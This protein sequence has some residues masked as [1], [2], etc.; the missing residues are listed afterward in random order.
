MMAS[1]AE[2]NVGKLGLSTFLFW[3]VAGWLFGHVQSRQHWIDGHFP[4]HDL[5]N[6][7]NEKPHHRHH[8]TT[9]QNEMKNKTTATTIMQKKKWKGK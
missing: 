7:E 5:Q 1:R 9:K 8:P 3:Y 6:A 2:E 4:F